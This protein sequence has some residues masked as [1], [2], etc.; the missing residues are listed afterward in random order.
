MT[1]HPALYDTKRESTIS[2]ASSEASKLSDTNQRIRCVK[3]GVLGTIGIGLTVSFGFLSKFTYLCLSNIPKDA[4][5]L[6]GCVSA[7]AAQGIIIISCIA[8]PIYCC[9][10]KR[11]SRKQS[12]KKYHIGS[13]SLD[14]SYET[15]TQSNQKQLISEGLQKKYRMLLS[16]EGL[17]VSWKEIN[18]TDDTNVVL[19][20]MLLNVGR[21]L[22]YGYS[23]ALLNLMG[24]HHLSRSDHLLNKLNFSDIYYFQ[25]WIFLIENYREVVI[26]QS[27]VTSLQN[28]PKEYFEDPDFIFLVWMRKMN[29][30]L[31]TQGV[32]QQG[33]DF[34]L[35]STAKGFQTQLEEDFH[36]TIQNMKNKSLLS[37]ET[38][39]YPYSDF[40]IAG[41]LTIRNM[42]ELMTIGED[43]AS[44]H[45]HKHNQRMLFFQFSDRFRFH[46]SES[47]IKGMYEFTSKKQF[48][49]NLLKYIQAIPGYKK[50][51]V[52]ST[53]FLIPKTGELMTQ[54]EQSV[55][56]LE[57]IQEQFQDMKS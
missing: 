31:L 37:L 23:F 6:A 35:S 50:V 25:F 34:I 30:L 54:R 8:V 16:S 47:V 52:S 40:T 28:C 10:R 57:I 41:Y 42:P 5:A 19:S 11:R 18:K 26:G 24:S 27:A 51:V 46:D 48:C 4:S 17:L 44:S 9:I 3:K 14:G 12:M 2:Y 29:K 7:V 21:R 55:S 22:D 15:L 13:R 43:D 39:F 33:K 20:R 38:D 1:I 56:R 49:E 36:L 32:F 53:I 45:F